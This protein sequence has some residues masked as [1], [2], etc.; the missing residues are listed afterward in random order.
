MFKVD[1]SK[2]D[3]TTKEV[4]D[5]TVKLAEE[6]IEAMV[7]ELEEYKAKG[8]ERLKQ[9][10]EWIDNKE[11]KFTGEIRKLGGGIKELRIIIIFP[12]E[13]QIIYSLISN[14]VDELRDAVDKMKYFYPECDWSAFDYKLR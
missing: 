1:L 10:D 14:K 11:I 7:K 5:G 8:K 4:F 12:D 6:E 2:T 3:F 9:L 13:T